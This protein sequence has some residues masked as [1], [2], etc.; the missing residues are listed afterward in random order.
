MGWFP[1]HSAKY[2]THHRTGNHVTYTRFLITPFD[3]VHGITGRSKQQSTRYLWCKSI[4]WQPAAFV[5]LCCKGLNATGK[6]QCQ[7]IDLQKNTGRW[8]SYYSWFVRQC[9][10]C[11]GQRWFGVKPENVEGKVL[12][13][14]YF[15]N[16]NIENTFQKYFMFNAKNKKPVHHYPAFSLR[17]LGDDISEYCLEY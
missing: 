8:S 4:H 15:S 9:W 2:V 6:R 1:L 5:T 17:H 3:S 16:I 10:C 13:V 12:C 7:Q 14:F 11:V